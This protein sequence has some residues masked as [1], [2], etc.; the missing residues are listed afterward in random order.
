MSRNNA[1]LELTP[2]SKNGLFDH[3]IGSRIQKGCLIIT[4]LWMIDKDHLCT[5]LKQT[6]TDV[7]G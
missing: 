5:D 1:Q 6:G 2:Q 3:I 7:R 4:K